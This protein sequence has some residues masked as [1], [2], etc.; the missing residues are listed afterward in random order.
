MNPRS[1]DVKSKLPSDIV[2][3][4]STFLSQGV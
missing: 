2:D 1:K 4:D 3:M